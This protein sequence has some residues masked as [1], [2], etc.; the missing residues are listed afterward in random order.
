MELKDPAATEAHFSQKTREMGTA[1][2]RKNY[3]AGTAT[4]F[5]DDLFLIGKDFAAACGRPGLSA[6]DVVGAI[7][8]VIAEGFDAGEVFQ[9]LSGGVQE[10]F[11]DAEIVRVAVHVRYRSLEGYH[12]VA[13][14]DQ[15]FLEAVGQSVGSASVF[16]SRRGPRVWSVRVE[17]GI[18]LRDDHDCRRV[19][20]LGLGEGVLHPGDVAAL[21]AAY[22]FESGA[23]SHRLL[24]EPWMLSVTYV[25]PR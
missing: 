4:R 9:T 10:W 2:I 7:F 22:S 12:L 6:V 16:G 19:E 3:G 5:R 23:T 13:E 24:H 15:E 8:L 17:A 14:G 18:G 1:V 25:T 20:C 11:I 21:R